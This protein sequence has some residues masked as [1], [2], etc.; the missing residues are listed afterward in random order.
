VTAQGG[1]RVAVIGAGWAGLAAAVRLA[2]AGVPCTV[3]EAAR[4]LGGRARRVDWTMNDGRTIALDNG[5][6]I[7]VGAYR[8]TLAL[9]EQVG[10]DC[11]RAFERTPLSLIG[12]SGFAMTAARLPAPWHLLL[13]LIT[14]SK[15]NAGERWAVVRFLSK[16][17][18]IGWTL[19]ED[20]TVDVLLTAWRQPASLIDKLWRPLSIAALNTP[21][22]AASAQVFLNVLR[23]SLG[24]DAASSDLLL[25]KT[26]LGSLLPD[27]A[28]AYLDGRCTIHR[29]LRI[30]NLRVDDDGVTLAAGSPTL[31]EPAQRFDAAVLA[32]PPVEAARLLAPMALR[33]ARYRPL[34]AT[35]ER[36]VFQ[37]IVSAWLRYRQAP[38]WPARMMALA[39]AAH[40]QCFG[41][42]V[43]DRSDRLDS[44]GGLVACVIS[45]DGPHRAL[46]PEPLLAAIAAQ[47]ARQCRS[48]HD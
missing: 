31:L 44:D 19:P 32:V 47:L 13:A 30:Q 34:V 5:Q 24:A 22:E 12:T 41:Q 10:I 4:T 7:V 37:P 40:L 14:A 2:D 48:T 9:L 46:E 25:P 23:D 43:F 33:D 29:G 21:L 15:M 6:H 17:K 36:F 27:A 20:R 16:A 42:W 18:R 26:D 45:A 1:P 11:G 3:F 38:Y 28:A 39:E 8:Q 35:C